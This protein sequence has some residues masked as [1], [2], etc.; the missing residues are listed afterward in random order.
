MWYPCLTYNCHSQ[1]AV[2][3]DWLNCFGVRQDT[4]LYSFWQVASILLQ[5]QMC[6][7]PVLSMS[8]ASQARPWEPPVPADG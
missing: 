8:D 7:R 5:G 3:L 4:V 6:D 2:C 1:Q